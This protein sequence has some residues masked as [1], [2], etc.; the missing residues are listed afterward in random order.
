MSKR[1]QARVWR[2]YI[3]THIEPIGL[4]ESEVTEKRDRLDVGKIEKNKRLEGDGDLCSPAL[5]H[6]TMVVTTVHELDVPQSLSKYI[7]CA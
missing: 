1:T 5:I 4:R 3:I 7:F 6:P 2:K